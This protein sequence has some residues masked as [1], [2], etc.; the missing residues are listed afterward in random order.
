MP[1]G[2]M[3]VVGGAL[4]G[5]PLRAPSGSVTRPTPALVRKS[6]FDALEALAARGDLP[7]RGYALDLYAGSGALGIEA[8]SRGWARA[9]FVERD[10]AALRTLRHNLTQL[11]LTARAQVVPGDVRRF[12]D[13]SL[14]LQPHFDLILASPPYTEGARAVLQLLAPGAGPALVVLQHPTQEELPACSGNVQ[15][16][17]QRIYGG[18]AVDLYAMG[19][20]AAPGQA[21]QG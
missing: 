6:I 17:W 8:L 1:H 14:P 9:C 11:A 21:P 19:R 7:A 4:R 15:R 18:T 3:R 2:A 12:L 16:V 20:T 10:P 5:R 13:N